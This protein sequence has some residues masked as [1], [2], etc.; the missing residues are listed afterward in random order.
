[1]LHFKRLTKVVVLCALC[2]SVAH[3]DGSSR[4]L[5]A[6]TKLKDAENDALL[7]H[8]KYE[9]GLSNGLELL[10]ADERVLRARLELIRSSSVTADSAG[11]KQEEQLLRALM[12]NLKSQVELEQQ[13]GQT[14]SCMKRKLYYLVQQIRESSLLDISLSEVS[15]EYARLYK[16]YRSALRRQYDHG[17]ISYAEMENRSKVEPAR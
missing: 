12:G 16:A 13:A 9:H 11:Y 5:R 15:N 1:M 8:E 10:E 4:I 2:L 6:E 14:I 17:L 3:G 7:V